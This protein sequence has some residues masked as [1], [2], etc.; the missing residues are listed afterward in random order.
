MNNV[1]YSS[2][3]KGLQTGYRLGRTSKHR[4]PP[5]APAEY[6]ITEVDEDRMIT[7]S[8]DRMITE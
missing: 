4:T 3:L 6:M 1:D 2:F 5:V 8:G 7:E